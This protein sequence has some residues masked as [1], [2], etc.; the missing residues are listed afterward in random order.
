MICHGSSWKYSV[1]TTYCIIEPLKHGSRI[2]E[3]YCRTLFAIFRI[4]PPPPHLR[5]TKRQE[6]WRAK[7][8]LVSMIFVPCNSKI[9]VYCPCRRF[10]P[11]QS[12]PDQSVSEQCVPTL[13]GPQYK[14]LAETWFLWVPSRPPGKPKLR[15]SYPTHGPHKK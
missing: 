4:C 12:V 7:R 1:I 15:S 11:D 10:V 8:E 3:E 13:H 2:S 9:R 6:T 5:Y 14:L